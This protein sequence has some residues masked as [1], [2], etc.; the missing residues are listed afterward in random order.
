MTRQLG[1]VEAIFARVFA[2]DTTNKTGKA[3]EGK[4]VAV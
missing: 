3:A 4:E 2:L 1:N